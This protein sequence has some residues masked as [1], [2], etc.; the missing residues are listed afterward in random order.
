M[1]ITI[2]ENDLLQ[3]TEKMKDFQGN[4]EE[5]INDVLHNFGGGAIQERIYR[6]MPVSN[7]KKGTHAKHSASLRSINA[8][9]SVTVTTTKRFQYLYFPDDGTT[10]RRH[11]GNQ[12]F[13]KSGGEAVKSEIVEK[14]IEQ[15]V[16]KF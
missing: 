4:A 6:L 5:V 15:L 9:L 12:Q 13:F 14:C 10:T 8:N 11:V 7:K 3:L 2:D 1:R 16:N